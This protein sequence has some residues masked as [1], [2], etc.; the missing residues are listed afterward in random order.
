MS[1]VI[2]RDGLRFRW[3]L[4]RSGRV[5]DHVQH[6]QRSENVNSDN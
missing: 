2:A 4:D 5:P 1:A 3:T 6:L